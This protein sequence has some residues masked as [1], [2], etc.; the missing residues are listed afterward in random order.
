M[1]FRSDV[2]LDTLERFFRK[3]EVDHCHGFEGTACV[4]WTG[5]KTCGQGKHIK[6]GRFKY[7]RFAWLVHR[8][9]AKFVHGQEIDM[10]QVDHGCNRPL[11]VSHL[12]A[13]SPEANRELQWI[14]VQVG[15][16]DNPRPQ[17]EPDDCPVPFYP[18]PEWH[19]QLRELVG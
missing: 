12:K 9:A 2:S 15:I 4:L 7:K 3:L 19:K 16:D 5:G 17:F 8:W 1:I 6:Y 13:M 11:C 18:E 14:R 10:R